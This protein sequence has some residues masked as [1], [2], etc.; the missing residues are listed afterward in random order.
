[1][2]LDHWNWLGDINPLV[3]Q[4]W[5]TLLITASAF[6]CGGLVGVERGRAQKPAGVRTLILICLG[7]AIFTQISFLVG[8]P[9]DRTRI[10]S[11]IVSGIGFLGA[12]AIMQDRGYI[13]GVTT[14]ASIWTTAAIGLVLGSGHIAM[15]FLFTLVVFAVLR[16]E[17][18][19]D[20]VVMGSCHW[21][22]LDLTYDPAAGQTRLRIQAVLDEHAHEGPVSFESRPDGS[23]QAQ[24]SYCANHRQHRTYLSD[25]MALPALK[26]ARL[27]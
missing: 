13:I 8:S 14:G 7:S 1:M 19:L 4:P 20:S 17:K 6:T 2:N 10:A 3:G 25:L 15:G 22:K 21:K 16:F 23:E 18:P 26:E 24:I 9:G 11:M 5:I 27:E 12:G